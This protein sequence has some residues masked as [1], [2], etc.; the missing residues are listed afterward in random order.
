VKALV[1]DYEVRKPW[2][3]NIDFLMTFHHAEVLKGQ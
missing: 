2:L 3:G 1:V